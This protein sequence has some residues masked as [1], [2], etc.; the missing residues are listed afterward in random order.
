[1]QFTFRDNEI[2]IESALFFEKRAIY[3]FNLIQDTE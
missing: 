1:M 2:T 3:L